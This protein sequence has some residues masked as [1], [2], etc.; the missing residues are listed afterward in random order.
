MSRLLSDSKAFLDSTQSIFDAHTI[1][2]GKIHAGDH[3]EAMASVDTPPTLKPASFYKDCL[4]RESG[5][6][7]AL[8]DTLS[9]TKN[10]KLITLIQHFKDVS[11]IAVD[12]LKAME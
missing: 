8:D 2:I 11:H 9:I 12:A 5:F 10:A 1:D 4:V 3:D 6:L 7:L